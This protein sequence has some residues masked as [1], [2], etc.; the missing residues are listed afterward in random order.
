MSDF[1][2]GPPQDPDRL[3]L[4][5]PV[6]SGTEGVLFRGWF[7]QEEGSVD[8]AVKML[9]PAHLQ[10]LSS[11]STQWRQQVELLGRVR[12]QGLVAV[13]GGF[14]GPL[15]H[16][17]GEADLGT[18]TLFLLMDWVD[19]ISLDRWAR[20]LDAPEPEQLLLALVPVAAALDLLHSG[21]ATG[22]VAVVHRDV[23]PANILVR[24]SGETVLVDVGSAHG[25]ADDQ[26]RSGVVGTP[27]YIAPEALRDGHYGPAADRYSLGAVVFFLLTGSDPPPAASLEDLRR[28]L[29]AAPL[30]VNRPDVITHVLAMLDVEPDRRPD[31][32]AN[33]V[34]QLRRSSLVALPGEGP[35]PP[36]APR[37]NPTM[38]EPRLPRKTSRR[39]LTATLAAVGLLG[40]VL[41]LVMNGWLP[42]RRTGSG[43]GDIAAA[44]PT[45]PA[46]LAVSG[47]SALALDPVGGLSRSVELNQLPALPGALVGPVRVAGDHVV[48]ILRGQAGSEAFSVPLDLTGPGRSLG[49]ATGVLPAD[50]AGRVRLVNEQHDSGVRAQN[51]P[52]LSSSARVVD[53]EGG[54]PDRAIPV[55]ARHHVLAAM[56]A[57]VVEW[58]PANDR[59]TPG[60]IVLRDPATRTVVRELA[61]S[62]YPVTAEGDLVA[63]S[64][65]PFVEI[66]VTRASTG[67]RRTM[68]APRGLEFS[69]IGKVAPDGLHAAF[70]V[71][72][73]R[74]VASSFPSAEGDPPWPGRWAVFDLSSGAGTVI[75]EATHRDSSVVW[76]PSSD[77]VYFNLDSRRLATYHLGDQTHEVLKLP[78]NGG[79]LVAFDSHIDLFAAPETPSSTVQPSAD[80]TQLAYH[81]RSREPGKARGCLRLTTPEVSEPKDLYCP[82]VGSPTNFLWSPDG[83]KLAFDLGSTAEEAVYVVDADGSNVR[84]LVTGGHSNRLASWSPDGEEVAIAHADV[85]GSPVI[86]RVRVDGGGSQTLEA[87][88]AADFQLAAWWA[89]DG[90]QLLFARAAEAEDQCRFALYI[91]R[92]D[93]SGLRRLACSGLGMPSASWSP[94][95]QAIVFTR[96]LDIATSGLFTVRVDGSDETRLD[97]RPTLA[98]PTWSPDGRRVAY[99]APVGTHDELFVINAD[100]SSRHQVSAGSAAVG[101]PAWSFD[102]SRIAFESGGD[103]WVVPAGGGDAQQVTRSP[104]QNG[105][106]NWRPT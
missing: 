24:Q 35:R 27:G 13:R 88:R 18:A 74:A 104:F 9:H 37:R 81:W 75:E 26:S 53:V 80:A 54:A 85:G 61:P 103:I 14:I 62:A 97:T 68:T 92:I 3:H 98:G 7:Q 66:H 48:V 78:F 83:R 64:K 73:T 65:S 69:G 28:C 30:L 34:A 91:I 55:S 45:R 93:G 19:G 47:R 106:P 82:P 51:P 17:A 77:R 63:W 76:A 44:Q 31:A 79:H 59:D 12:V 94:D 46:L 102:G 58:A 6:A 89:P 8:I 33:W 40:V 52:V 1:R 100:G 57:G 87:T 101:G 20:T 23:K 2:V 38:A 105:G 43:T 49:T 22:G 70:E 15:P 4:G 71:I 60:A 10:R 11:W 50:E 72:A 5:P 29:V 56:R 86:Q 36:R 32:L 42:N 96:R 16:P 21:V 84:S 95:G 99:T 90:R 41:A 25:I 39:R 67:E